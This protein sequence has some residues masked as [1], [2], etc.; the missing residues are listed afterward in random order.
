[1]DTEKPNYLFIGLTVAIC[2]LFGALMWLFTARISIEGEVTAW[3]I[4]GAFLLSVVLTGFVIYFKF[5]RANNKAQDIV[6]WAGIVIEL[7]I[8]AATFLTV[9]H[10]DLLRGTDAEKFAGLVS[11]F[12]V[13]TTVFCLVLF[14]ALDD[15]T[16]E[17][18]KLAATRRALIR[19]MYD[20]ELNSPET[21]AIVREQARHDVREQIAQEMRVPSYQLGVPQ[22]RNGKTEAAA[23][24]SETK[25]PD[26]Q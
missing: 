21:A 26:F 16:K 1:M 13:I 4:R 17:N 8:M 18:Q 7:G 14:F 10:P 25:P 5:G 19:S 9:V 15:S 23:Y 11:G 6:L 3:V 24:H 12:N 22:A 2:I 20:Q